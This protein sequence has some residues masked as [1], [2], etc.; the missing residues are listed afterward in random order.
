MTAHVRERQVDAV[1]G[2][3]DR[4]R[5]CLRRP[6]PAELRERCV[7]L[8][9]HGHE[10]GLSGHV[11]PSECRIERQDVGI[12]PDWEHLTQLERLE[13]QHTQRR[14]L[15][16]SDECP[17]VRGVDVDA[18][19]VPDRGHARGGGHGRGCCRDAYSAS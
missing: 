8:L 6:V 5:V 14:A 2:G 10:P 11:Q 9:E 7:P 19:G 1:R 4:D 3:I 15:L 18:M 13:I 16:S 17:A 12:T